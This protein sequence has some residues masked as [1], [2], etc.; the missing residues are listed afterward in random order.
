MLKFNF[1]LRTR[2]GQTV[3]NIQLYGKDLSDAERKLRQMYRNCEVT[4]YKIINSDNK[5]A[6][7]A[8]I[9]DVLS[10]IAKDS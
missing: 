6:Q 3:E 4:Q 1:S 10:L 9:E 7:S 2:D 5:I 8:D